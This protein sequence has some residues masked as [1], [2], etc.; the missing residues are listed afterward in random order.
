LLG[1]LNGAEASKRGLD[2]SDT[3]QHLGEVNLTTIN[4]PTLSLAR[5]YMR[6]AR[7]SKLVEIRECLEFF[8]ILMKGR[9]WSINANLFDFSWRL[10]GWM[11]AGVLID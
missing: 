11:T 6:E 8:L 5:A 10:C 1:E 7:R 2:Y 3:C 9:I 4:A